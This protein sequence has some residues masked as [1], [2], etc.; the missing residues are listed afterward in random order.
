[1]EPR[2]QYAKTKDG[3]SIAYAT[4]GQGPPLVVCPRSF[5]QFSRQ[6]AAWHALMERLGEGRLLVLYDGRGTGLSERNVK[7]FSL[8]ARLR[9]LEAV[10]RAARIRRFALY[11]HTF[12]GAAAVAYAAHHQRQVSQ[13]ILYGT[14]SCGADVMPK[15][16]LNPLIELCR[17]NWELASQV[18]SDTSLRELQ[19]DVALQISAFLRASCSGEVAAE[20]LEQGYEI[21][22]GDLLPRVKAP[23]LVIH[24]RG[25]TIVS[26]GLGQKLAAG[27]PNARFIPLEGTIH[28]PHL[29]DT[30]SVL[31]A[32]E[33]F[34]GEGKEAEAKAE[35][36]EGMAV[37]LFADI[38]NSTALTEQLGDAAFREKARKLDTSLRVI[39]GESGGTPV[40]GKV[41]GDGVLAVFTSA[42]EAID[43]ALRC[44]ANS[45]PLELQLHLGIHAGDVIREGNNVYGGAVNIA[46]RIAAASEPGEVLVSDTVRSLARTSAGVAFDDRGEHSLKG[47]ADPQRLFAVRGGA[48][49]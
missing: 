28:D 20:I 7:D 38:A 10:V 11:G 9:D 12:S 45:E 15:E 24:R 43:C 8:E 33:E 6:V 26:S 30:E 5:D 16:R 31:R 36:P 2:V 17:S 46:A 18:F 22:V 23:T 19:P 13:L 39:I 21:D 37:L 42:R 34:L 4:V 44:N 25:D 48:D 14:F 49:G 47:V 32:I 3:V 41:L 1:M 27:I 35:L 29:G 40:E